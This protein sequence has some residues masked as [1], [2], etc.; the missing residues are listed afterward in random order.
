[1]CDVLLQ[2]VKI[3]QL[4]TKLSCLSPPLE[5]LVTH[6]RQTKINKALSSRTE[7]ISHTSKLPKVRTFVDG[8][9]L[10]REPLETNTLGS[11]YLIYGAYSVPKY[12]TQ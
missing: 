1:M 6:Y 7:E 4:G 12:V 11:R 8:A 2:L 5:C 10:P 9:L 3:A